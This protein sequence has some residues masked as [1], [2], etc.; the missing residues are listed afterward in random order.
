MADERILKKCSDGRNGEL[1][2]S[3]TEGFWAACPT[4]QVNPQVSAYEFFDDFMDMSQGAVTSK[5]DVDATNGTL[6]L[7][8]AATYGLGGMGVFNCPGTAND[9]INAK[10]TDAN[11]ALGAFKITASS[12]KKLWYAIRFK[13]DVVTYDCICLGLLDGTTTKPFAD[14]TGVNDGEVAGGVYFRTVSGL[15]G[16][17]GYS[18]DFAT[19]RNSVEAEVKAGIKTL[20]ASTWVIAGFFF[21]GVSSVLPFING[22]QQA[23]PVLVTAAT[24]PY[25]IGLT[26]YIGMLDSVGAAKNLVVDWV[27]CVQER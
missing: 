24:F 3:P 17:G 26:P 19:S 16:V 23:Y 12:G 6:K 5:W 7:A 4:L 22:V 1:V 13:L 20:V 25:D 27:K 10:V 15:L 8:Q 14:N 18:L 21:D 9:Y 2:L 11:A